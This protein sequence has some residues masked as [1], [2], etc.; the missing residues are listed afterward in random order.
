[1][2]VYVWWVR[3][4][5]RLF[6]KAYDAVSPSKYMQGSLIRVEEKAALE[7]KTKKNK[8]FLEGKSPLA[9]LLFLL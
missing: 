5:G 6:N 7:D 2:H 3:A 9:S 4:R 1:M 8:H